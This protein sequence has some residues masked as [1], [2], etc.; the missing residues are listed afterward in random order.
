MINII[1]ATDANG[2][3]GKDN[4]LPWHLPGDLERFKRLTMGSTI[5]MGRKTFESIGKP[6]PGRTNIVVTRSQA[7]KAE[8]VLVCT[9][10]EDLLH[11]AKNM[12]TFVI[13]GS[14][15]YNMFIPVTERVYITRIHHKFE[16]D[17]W[18]KLNEWEW[19]EVDTTLVQADNRNQYTH[20]F[21]ILER[22]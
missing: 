5:I 22:R 14:E 17:S 20:T 8:G 3:I 19:D 2:A 6:L 16:A 1:V 10:P 18:F 21:S 13:G 7:F 11:T 9:Y 15:I 12:H 4:K